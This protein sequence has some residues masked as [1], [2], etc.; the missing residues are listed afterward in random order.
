MYEYWSYSCKCSH[1]QYGEGSALNWN[2]ITLSVEACYLLCTNRQSPMEDL[3]WLMFSFHRAPL[4]E[5]CTLCFRPVKYC[6][7]LLGRYADLYALS[8][9]GR[10]LD[11]CELWAFISRECAW[12][13]V[14]HLSPHLHR[15]SRLPERTLCSHDLLHL[16]QRERCHTETIF[17]TGQTKCGLKLTCEWIS[18]SQR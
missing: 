10:A 15:V 11:G 8:S 17:T 7:V 14:F 13:D 4:N 5:R 16:F 9:P 3:R 6:R 1:S 18:S 12:F 2:Y